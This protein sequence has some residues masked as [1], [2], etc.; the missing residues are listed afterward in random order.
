MTKTIYYI[1]H[2]ESDAN[3]GART[4]D[5]HSICLTEKGWEQARGVKDELLDKVRHIVASP[6]RRAQ[7]TA[8]PLSQASGL[9]IE[10]WPIEEFL[11]LDPVQ[12]AG[13]SQA[14]RR[15]LRE[16]YWGL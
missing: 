6:Y 5:E 16:H 14:E 9:A 4:S 10:T 13:T 8:G 11:Y 15:D 7:D 3:A 2:G 1:R 12:C